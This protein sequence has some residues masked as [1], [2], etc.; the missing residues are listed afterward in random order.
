MAKNSLKHPAAGA[1]L[2]RARY[3]ALA[4]VALPLCATSPRAQTPPEPAA[5]DKPDSPMLR[6]HRCRSSRVVAPARAGD[7]FTTVKMNVLN[8]VPGSSYH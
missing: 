3:A 8:V 7:A 4:V 2:R 5:P 1:L 6:R